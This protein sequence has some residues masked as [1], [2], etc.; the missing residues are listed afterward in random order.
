MTDNLIIVS[1]FKWQTWCCCLSNKKNKETECLFLCGWSIRLDRKQ[2]ICKCLKAAN[3]ISTWWWSSLGLLFNLQLRLLGY[4]FWIRKVASG[5]KKMLFCEFE[6]SGIS[7]LHIEDV[8]LSVALVM[9]CTKK[10]SGGYCVVTSNLAE[11]ELL[12]LTH[13]SWCINSDIM[14]VAGLLEL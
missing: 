8:I 13:F 2:D 4:C 12:I 6:L 1:T 9:C 3:S 7:S 10:R 5:V 11:Q 14:A